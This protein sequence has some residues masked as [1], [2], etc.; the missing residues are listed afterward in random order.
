MQLSLVLSA[1]LLTFF[2]IRIFGDSS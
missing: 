1:G 2:L